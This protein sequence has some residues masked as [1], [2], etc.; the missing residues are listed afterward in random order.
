MKTF[1]YQS[2]VQKQ[3]RFPKRLYFSH[4]AQLLSFILTATAED[5]SLQNKVQHF[6]LH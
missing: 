1:F 5:Q 3:K 4:S 6:V 2:K